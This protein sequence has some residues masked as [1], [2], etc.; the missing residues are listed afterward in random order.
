MKKIFA[1]IIFSLGLLFGT[2]QAQQPEKPSVART[3]FWTDGNTE[4]FLIAKGNGINNYTL[5]VVSK[6]NRLKISYHT[7]I[8]SSQ[9]VLKELIPVKII[10]GRKYYEFSHHF[11]RT[12]IWMALEFKLN[13]KRVETLTRTFYNDIFEVVPND[14]FLNDLPK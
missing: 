11:S 14:Q 13:E 4:V 12:T 9:D 5:M 8:N 6:G 2:I 7:T 10:K 3:A 1:L